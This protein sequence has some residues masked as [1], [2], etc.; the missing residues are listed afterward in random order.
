MRNKLPK[1]RDEQRA[2][3]EKEIADI[4]GDIERLRSVALHLHSER[5]SASVPGL[6][7][8]HPESAT[9]PEALMN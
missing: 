3:I 4:S 9:R 2:V 5:A 8:K 7:A 1:N 6:S